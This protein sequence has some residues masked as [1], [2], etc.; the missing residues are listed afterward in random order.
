VFP[1]KVCNIHWTDGTVLVSFD[2]AALSSGLC[3]RAGGSFR[4]HQSRTTNWFLNCG[5]GTNNKAELLGLW[6]SLSLASFWSLNHLHVLGDSK[7]IID[8]INQVSK[9]NS[10][11]LEGWKQDTRK[12]AS[13]FSDIQ[14]SH[15]SRIHNSVD[16]A[17]SKRALSAVAGRLSIYHSDYGYA[18][19]ITSYNLFEGD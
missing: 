4:A 11:H 7:L 18:S 1:N 15:I 3:C 8:W 17:L 12:L 5:A 10:V 19:Q 9:L 16:D 13:K 2:G 14:F 6:V